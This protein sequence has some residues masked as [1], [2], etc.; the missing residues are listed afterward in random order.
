MGGA[1]MV[2]VSAQVRDGA[3]VAGGD[4]VDV[5]MELD[6]QPRE[7]TVPPDFASALDGEVSARRFFDGLSHSNKRRIVTPIDDAKTAE[8]R[9]RRIAKA[10]ERL[11]E[12]RI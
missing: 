12:G 3:G 2:G 7:I 5:D 11:R 1:F 6:T 10:V 9:Q 4:E 8:N